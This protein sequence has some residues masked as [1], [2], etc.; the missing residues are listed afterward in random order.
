M[1]NGNLVPESF[2]RYA[3]L[4][5]LDFDGTTAIESPLHKR[6]HDPRPL[7]GLLDPAAITA[8]ADVGEIEQ[9]VPRG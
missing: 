6:S 5:D 7:R 9:C 8:G 1:T 4:D 2:Q 3:D